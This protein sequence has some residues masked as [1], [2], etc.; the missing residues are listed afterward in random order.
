MQGREIFALCLVFY[1]TFSFPFLCCNHSSYS[2]CPSSDSKKAIISGR[3]VLARVS[4][5]ASLEY[6]EST[7]AESDFDSD[8]GVLYPQYSIKT[9]RNSVTV[10]S[11]YLLCYLCTMIK[12]QL[13][14]EENQK[15]QRTD[16]K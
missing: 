8:K 14:F 7:F 12:S 1:T 4:I 3:K 9:N 11:P 16:K 10:V 13:R 6:E 5:S 2:R 15:A